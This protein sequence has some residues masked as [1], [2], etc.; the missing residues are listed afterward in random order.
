M[1]LS[2]I[3]THA[4][5]YHAGWPKDIVTD[6]L[7]VEQPQ[8]FL[9]A[10][11]ICHYWLLYSWRTLSEIMFRLPVA[12][13]QV[14]YYCECLQ[15]EHAVTSRLLTVY[16]DCNSIGPTRKDGSWWRV[17]TKRDPLEKGIANHLIIL[18]WRWTPQVSRWPSCYWRRVEK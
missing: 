17:L 7:A 5:I 18:A 3:I 6:Q 9:S 16:P 1:H 10:M 15:Q 12:R 4:F 14:P 13:K 8:T 11:A 2:E